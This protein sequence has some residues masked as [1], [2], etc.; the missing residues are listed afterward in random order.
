MSSAYLQSEAVNQDL[1]V[2]C[3]PTTTRGWSDIPEYAL[4]EG[5]LLWRP[6]QRMGAGFADIPV[7]DHLRNVARQYP[8]KLAIG[9]GVNRLTYSELFR[10]VETLS[11][12]IAAVVPEGQA[13]G[14][15]QANSAWYAVAILASMAAGRPSVPLN[16]R[17]PGSRIIEIVNAARLGA[18]IGAGNVRPIDLAQEVLWI[19]IAA[20]V[21]PN[22]QSQQPQLPSVSVDAPAMVLYTS[23]S[24]GRPKGI[25]NSQRS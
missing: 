23:G 17:D 7:F 21:A 2:D 1:R 24:T 25:V 3:R 22:G 10:A 8:D 19:D 15:L 16:M 12:R 13:V 11:Y 6:Y 20:G 14:I 9:D 5:E 18:I 4:D